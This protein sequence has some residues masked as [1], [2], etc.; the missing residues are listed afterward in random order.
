MKKVPEVNCQGRGTHNATV[1]KLNL[2]RLIRGSNLTVP[3]QIG[4]QISERGLRPGLNRALGLRGGDDVSSGLFD[5]AEPVE[6]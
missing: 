6:L 2:I 5:Y 3:L 4:D 1:V